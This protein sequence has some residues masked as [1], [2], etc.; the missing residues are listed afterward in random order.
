MRLPK[1]MWLFVALL[2]PIAVA[3]QA[4][5]MITMDQ[6][7]HH[8]LALQNEYVKVFMVAIDPGDAIKMHSH[9]HDTVAIAIGEQTVTV[10]YPDKPEVHLKTPDGQLRMQ[11]TGY[12]H[13]TRLDA[14][15]YH[16]VAVE[17]IHSQSNQRNLCSA[18]M[19]NKPLNCPE[20][21]ATSA[22]EKFFVKPQFESDQTHIQLV[23]LFPDQKANIGSAQYFQLIVALDPMSLLPAS[24]SGPAK[25]LRPGEFFWVDK[26]AAF[27]ALKNDSKAEARFIRFEFVPDNTVKKVN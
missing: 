23:N 7:P 16:T 22:S 11:Q 27:R 13:S 15:I 1:R 20:T 25:N 17:L 4:P 5:A 18:V 9:D 14:G 19:A 6:E 26:G 8:H 3:G 12:V 10:G 24:G 2:L 21:P